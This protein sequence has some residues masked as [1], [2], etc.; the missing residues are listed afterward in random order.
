VT[1]VEINPGY[2][3][4]IASKPE[5]ASVL[6]N[7]K[8]ELVIDDGRRWLRAH[9]NRRYDAVVANTAIHFRDNASNVLSVE[10]QELVRRHLWHGGTLFYNTTES[11]RVM[12]TGCG[13]F[14]YGVRLANFMVV[15]DQPIDLQPERWRAALLT[16]RVDGKPVI[17]PSQPSDQEVL[18][19]LLDIPGEIGDARLPAYKKRAEDCTSVL[20]RTTGRMP[21]TDDNMGTE[22]RYPLGLEQ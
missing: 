6:R 3:D 21:I 20:S 13:V 15:S 18:N 8:V 10:F 7:P 1:I 4:L 12:R 9:P 14:P 17:D 5:I 11:L 16:W 2:I 19:D 22:W